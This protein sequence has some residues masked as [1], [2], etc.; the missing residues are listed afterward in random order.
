MHMQHDERMA[1]RGQHVAIGGA[2][3]AGE[4]PVLHRAAVDEDILR[5]RLAAIERWQGGMAR[6]AHPLPLAFQGEGGGQKIAPQNGGDARLLIARRQIDGAALPGDEG[7]GHLRV[8]Q[9]QTADDLGGGHVLGA[10]RA[11]ELQP[12]RRG[13]EQIAHPHHGA[14]RSGRRAH[15]LH[16]AAGGA[17]FPGLRRAPFARGYCKARHGGDGGQGLAAKA[18]RADVDQIVPL[19]LGCGVALQ[20][21]AQIIAAH[22][23]AIVGDFYE[24]LAAV[25]ENDLDALR[26][27]VQGVLRQLLDNSER[28]LDDLSGGDAVDQIFR[29]AADG[30][31]GGLMIDGQSLSADSA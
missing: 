5:I 6:D 21:E 31:G 22:A 26:A 17:D 18:Q 28:P 23:A 29:Q 12:R 16:L 4:L 8:R 14:R 2:Q 11:Q 13:V 30:H 19:Q 25:A 7:K 1:A 20:G 27:R 15:I 9:R 3:R 10:R 24:G